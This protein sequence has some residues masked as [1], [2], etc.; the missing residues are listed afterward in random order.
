MYFRQNHIF[1]FSISILC[2]IWNIILYEIYKITF[3]KHM[4]LVRNTWKILDFLYK[5]ITIS[6]KI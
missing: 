2:Q 5:N 3:N 1:Y 4:I 6:Y